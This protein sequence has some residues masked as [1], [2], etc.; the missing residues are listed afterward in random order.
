MAPSTSCASRVASPSVPSRRPVVL[1]GQ[2]GLRRGARS[3]LVR[4][5]VGRR[6]VPG[7]RR[8]DGGAM[9]TGPQR[10]DRG[11]DRGGRDDGLHEDID[12]AATGQA[13][14]PGLLVAD[15]VADHP[16]VPVR[17]GL[18]DLLGRG[19]LHA[20]AAHRARDAA[21]A[22]VQQDGTL[23]SRR[24]PER[25]NDDGPAD[26]DPLPLPALEGFEEL[27]HRMGLA[28]PRSVGSPP[29][30]PGRCGAGGHPGLG[31][32]GH[33]G[34]CRVSGRLAPPSRVGRTHATQDLAKPLERGDGP[35]RQ[36]VVDVRVGRPHPAG[37]RLVPGRPG[38]RVEP[39]QSMA[40]ATKPGCLGCHDRRVA[41]VPAVGH[42][43]HDTA[44]A[45]RPP[46]PRLVERPEALPDPRPTGPVVDGI[47]DA[48]ERPVAVLVAQ[49]PG[50]ARESSPEDE[51]LRAH[52]RRRG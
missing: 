46:R 3:R 39:H 16:G 11:R 42:D 32:L 50:D 31:R 48:G 1:D 41:A 33:S 20:T 35:G 40:V 37:Q 15:A 28:V 21:V 34:E 22:R 19:A 2:R 9:P 25:S 8:D 44:R 52:L 38:Q 7:E 26:V 30:T 18:L 51:R 13:H 12:R 17:A 29:T 24:G 27:L 49:Q 5:E 10:L 4:T 14:V 36:E 6:R 45:Q 43:D 47:G 23:R